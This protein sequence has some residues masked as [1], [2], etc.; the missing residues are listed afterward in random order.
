MC[1]ANTLQAL[2][3]VMF[4]WFSG[5]MIA[6]LF[7]IST[8]TAQKEDEPTQVE[9]TASD[10]KLA[11][12][13]I[14]LLQK[15]PEFGNVLDL[16]WDLYDKKGQIPLLL[17]YIGNAAKAEGAPAVTLTIYAHLL[18][19]NDDL[20]GARDF[21]G[22]VL[23][24]QPENPIVLKASAEIADQQR[25]DAKALSLYTKAIN[26]IGIET[27]DGVKIRMRKAALHR[28]L[29]QIEEA[30]VIWNTLLTAYPANVELRTEVVA[31]L[32]QVGETDTAIK[33]LRD[34]ANRAKAGGP[35]Q[36]LS[37]LTELNRLYEFMND[38]DGAEAAAREG[39]SLIHF[40]NH[41]FEGLFTKLVRLHERFGRLSE[42][43]SELK[44]E[45]DQERPSEQAVVKLTEFYRLTADPESE[46]K[47]V[48][49]LTELV[50]ANTDYRV[51]HALICMENDRYEEAAEIL[52]LLLEENPNAPFRFTLLRCRV[53]LN[54]EGRAAAETMLSHYLEEK[55]PDADNQS[56]VLE[57]AREHYLDGIV[58]KM[59]RGQIDDPDMESAPIKLA[60]FL[61]ERGRRDQAIETLK[62]YVESAGEA[63]TDRA[64]RL[65]EVS[66]GFRDM[67][68]LPEAM[69]AINEAI[70]LFPKQANFH[71]A[72]AE[73]LMDRKAL[74]PT[75]DSLEKVRDLSIGL[76]KKSEIDQRI[77]SLL[78][79]IVDKPVEENAT[80]ASNPSALLESVEQYR[81]AA[82]AASRG[83]REAEE[84]PPK[85]LLAYFKNIV[86]EANENSTQETRYRAGWWAFKMQDTQECFNQLSKAKA[87]AKE[88]SV[89][90]E[91]LLLEMAVQLERP[92]FQARHLKMLSE[93]DPANQ[94][95]YLQQ[96]AE[97]RFL[98]GFEDEAIRTLK[99][100]AAKPDASLGTLKTLA[101]SY[102]RLSSN[103]R[104]IDVWRD[105]Y[106]RSNLFEKR[107]IIKQLTTAL[108]GQRM[109][110]EALK[111]QL[112]LI[113]RDTDP[114]QKR[115]Q[116]DTQLTLAQ[117]HFL[118]PWLREKYEELT[119]AKPFDRFFPEALAKIYRAAGNEDLAFE[120]MKKAYYMSG[121]DRD[122]LI[123]LG[124]MAGNSDDLKAA[125][126]YRRQLI[127]HSEEDASIE[128][129]KSLITMLEKD[130]RLKEA[131]L[132]R[133]R[134]E[135]KFGQDAD[136]LE[137][138]ATYY[139]KSGIID[140]EIR[141]L[142]KL[143]DLRPW[144]SKSALALA[145]EK[146]DHA[147]Y[148]GAMDACEKV[149]SA[150]NSTTRNALK[151]AKSG[152]LPLLPITN[153]GNSGLDRMQGIIERFPFLE[154][155]LQED[156][157]E[158]LEKNHPEFDRI[159]TA[160][161]LIHLRAIE[162][163]AGIISQQSEVK[164]SEW[165]SR[166]KRD[167]KASPTEKLWAFHYVGAGEETLDILTPMLIEKAA[168]NPMEK[169]WFSYFSILG[170][171]KAD[172]LKW[173]NENVVER[174][175]FPITGLFL[176]IADQGE[177]RLFP[178]GYD[179][180]VRD[181]SISE[182][183]GNRLFKELRK[184]NDF[185]GAFR[186]GE[187][188]GGRS[189]STSGDFHYLVSETA[190]R[191]GFDDQR[192]KWLRSALDLMHDRAIYSLPTY[193]TSTAS[194][195]FEATE[196]AT[197]K[198]ALLEEIRTW[199][200]SNPNADRGVNLQST[201]YL[202][203]LADRTDQAIEALFP[204]WEY[205]LNESMPTG[206]IDTD[207]ETE[208]LR[209]S[210]LL[211]NLRFSGSRFHLSRN[212]AARLFKVLETGT[213]SPTLSDD[214]QTELEEYEAE[215]I[216]LYLESLLPADR[217][218][219]LRLIAN[220]MADPKG[221]MLLARTLDLRGFRREAMNVYR[222][223]AIKYP[224]DYSILRGFLD[225]AIAAGE[226][227]AALEM[228]ER[229]L[230]ETTA[231]PNGMGLEDI[232]RYHAEFLLQLR[233]VE[234]LS[235][236]SQ[237]ES[238]TPPS[239]AAAVYSYQS[240]LARAYQKTGN[241]EAL[242]RLLKH[243]RDQGSATKIH[244]LAG[245]TLLSNRGDMEAALEWLREIKLDQKSRNIED[246]AIFEIASLTENE[247]QLSDLIR[248][249]E[250]YFDPELTVDVANKLFAVGMQTEARSALL[251]QARKNT[252]AESDARSQLLAASLRLDLDSQTIPFSEIES[253]LRQLLD[254]L[255]NTAPRTKTFLELVKNHGT[256]EWKPVLEA[257]LNRPETKVAAWV[258]LSHLN[259]AFDLEFAEKLSDAEF[260][261]LLES[262][263]QF[264]E[265]GKSAAIQFVNA[266]KSFITRTSFQGDP[267]RQIAFFAAID[268]RLRLAEVHARLI[269]EVGADRFSQA[270]QSPR[271]PVFGARWH[272]A[273]KFS[274]ADQTD[275]AAALFRRYYD[276]IRRITN[277]HTPFLEDYA[278]FAIEQKDHSLAQE[279]L[280]RGFSKSVLMSISILAEFNAQLP[281]S[282]DSDQIGSLFSL[283]EG[284]LI[285]FE[286]FRR[287]LAESG[288]IQDTSTPL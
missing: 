46:E 129:W 85:R 185:A 219:P 105:A 233:D 157:V 122:L 96:W 70:S 275:F 222:A 86:K 193:Y 72:K 245:A 209:W 232:K 213:L 141:V 26:V 88:P 247:K 136:F 43:E 121:H 200:E 128:S 237:L 152:A 286:E 273:R 203:T 205:T 134:L 277:R 214:G 184:K 67:E 234:R 89:E 164:K 23:D 259:G 101:K 58:E 265:T 248:Q 25:R 160:P 284:Q 28:D 64:R 40:K 60:R 34:L 197:E 187:I 280:K 287:Q 133:R 207:D 238:A 51:R 104:Q 279:I 225:A 251:N 54:S 95:D 252:I 258:G 192:M 183:I 210:R 99:E 215:R 180:Y 146:F 79:G 119:R 97:V 91:K 14:L 74:N 172:L 243:M 107:Q 82:A 249:S 15:K 84:P 262:L 30:A 218:A 100:L 140:S 165:V 206:N 19:K 124:E 61:Q 162:V 59:L 126:Y 169:V 261:H 199:I 75:L 22:Q 18:R 170:N 71:L 244:F 143:V 260:D 161:E 81:K 220:R 29:N 179:D 155:N 285:E 138:M 204:L 196:S 142:E 45:A 267:E 240:A 87:E 116:F 16:L 171:Q 41:Q 195:L 153:S 257:H 68:L 92:T 69:R 32:L 135:S 230:S 37:A 35:E 109:P 49:R 27:E 39:L 239:T 283:S 271:L 44:V 13:Y 189:L 130:L 102:Q 80:P 250:K 106:R 167:E 276:S 94:D 12:H 226:P 118:L 127:A 145:L 52:D 24:S 148:D 211:S 150:A 224:D 288:K 33:V 186:A 274:D 63:K 156:L 168:E 272:L 66:V 98:L 144:D 50:P 111:I 149:L 263:I 208:R 31:F 202:E 182:N 228:I 120:A 264:D 17:E 36:R 21:Y 269:E 201:I 236:L 4:R 115:K 256:E 158:H 112:D 56:Q 242:L 253:P 163:A 154:E 2:G 5:I 76:E 190:G 125:I 235:Q 194:E 9:W 139:R 8:A 117:R 166:W 229:Y 278:R 282:L 176:A 231:I 151:N 268:D 246:E 227:R 212:Q 221:R 223:D 137:E 177:E 62:S 281:E 113:Q 57:F 241:D 131:D 266:R 110:E 77:F 173:I 254:S 103:Q 10:T 159:P 78:R 55:N 11:N 188:L 53:A 1:S 93:I 83:R 7:A 6:A 48:K 174:E 178:M 65:H 123:Q 38:F 132:I 90:V 175:I 191:I 255:Q 198:Q 42:L 147:D 114:I 270:S 3:L 217:L 20:D 216:A 108:V 181:L 73:I 47:W